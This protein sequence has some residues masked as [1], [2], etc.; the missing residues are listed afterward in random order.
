VKNIFETSFVDN[1]FI[2]HYICDNDSTMIIILRSASSWI[3][4]SLGWFF[5]NGNKVGVGH[6]DSFGNRN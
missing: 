5:T 2:Q 4:K 1:V 6:Y 3:E